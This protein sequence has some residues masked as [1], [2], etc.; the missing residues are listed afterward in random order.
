[1]ARAYAQALR[2]AWVHNSLPV[3]VAVPDIPLSTFQNDIALNPRAFAEQNP[4]KSC[5]VSQEMLVFDQPIHMQTSV[6]TQRPSAE[7]LRDFWTETESSWICTHVLPRN[8]YF[9]PYDL[10]DGPDPETLG[11]VRTTQMISKSILG[12]KIY[13][14]TEHHRWRDPHWAKAKTRSKWTGKSIISKIGQQTESADL[15]SGIPLQPDSAEGLRTSSAG[16][17][18]QIA[19][20]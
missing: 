6:I 18:T 14:K 4:D 3:A 10:K 17:R 9:S 13:P 5:T 1:M 11:P 2:S 19:E 20:S 7:E 15:P 16:L 12:E 8:T